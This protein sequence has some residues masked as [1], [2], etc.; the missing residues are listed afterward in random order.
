MADIAVK[1]KMTQIWCVQ[2]RKYQDPFFLLVNARYFQTQEAA[3]EFMETANKETK[4]I[5]PEYCWTTPKFIGE[6]ELIS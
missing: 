6:M 2:M 3:T 4:K 1:P 5:S